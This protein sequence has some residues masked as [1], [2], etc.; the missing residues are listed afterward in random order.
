MV[1]NGVERK[2]I[3]GFLLERNGRATGGALHFVQGKQAPTKGGG[4]QSE[5]ESNPS[6]LRINYH[7]AG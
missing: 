6:R 5:L 2:E 1:R 4:G 7:E 3:K